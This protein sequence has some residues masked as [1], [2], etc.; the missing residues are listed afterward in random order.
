MKPGNPI[1]AEPY[2]SAESK[3]FFAAIGLDAAAL[4]KHGWAL[5]PLERF[6]KSWIIKG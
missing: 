5:V 6:G 4:P 1:K 2:E 3:E